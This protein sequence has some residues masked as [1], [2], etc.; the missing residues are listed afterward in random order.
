MYYTENFKKQVVKKLLSPGVRIVDVTRKLNVGKSTVSK[1]KK[2][3]VHEVQSE[4][5]EIDVEELLKE[6]EIDFDELWSATEFIESENVKQPD[7]EELTI[8][9]IFAKGKTPSQYNMLEKYVIV[10]EYK[11]LFSGEAG[12]FLR[13][14]GLHSQYIK[15]W[16]E[17]IFAMSKK[18]IE[19]D[20]Y[21]QKLEEEKKALLKQVKGLERDKNEL[22]IL[23]ELKKKY[24]TLFHQGEEK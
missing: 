14:Y 17:E 23:I 16:E 13:T 5:K 1:W 4:V 9:K 21:I 15:L 7:Q 24:P 19:K 12:I 22:K 18:R 6:E 11:K 2:K 20:E 10:N 3:Y 8:D